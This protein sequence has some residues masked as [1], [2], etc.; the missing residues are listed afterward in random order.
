MYFLVCVLWF[1]RS[2]CVLVCVFSYDVIFM[3]CFKCVGGR[4]V[5]WLLF[6]LCLFVLVCVYV[7][8]LCLV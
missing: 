8:L 5:C 7:V 2:V 6:M 4:V 3:V 1:Y